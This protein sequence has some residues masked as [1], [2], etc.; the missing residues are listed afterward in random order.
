MA[1]KECY[2]P[3]SMSE[4]GFAHEVWQRMQRLRSMTNPIWIE[5]WMCNRCGYAEDVEIYE[6][7]DGVLGEWM[8]AE[9]RQIGEP[10]CGGMMEWFGDTEPSTKGIAE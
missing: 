9:P 10:M 6:L 5:K 3:W 8:C 2:S 1:V 4:W 7:G